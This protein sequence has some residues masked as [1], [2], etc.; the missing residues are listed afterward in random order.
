MLTA[1]IWMTLIGTAMAFSGLPQISRLV[2]RRSA[3]DISLSMFSMF[4]FGQAWWVWYGLLINSICL[5]V[6]N[7]VA[8]MVNLVIVFL[9]VKYRG[10]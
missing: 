9:A 8:F 1:E 4:M 7:S 6:T 3:D 5:I 2:K 10:K